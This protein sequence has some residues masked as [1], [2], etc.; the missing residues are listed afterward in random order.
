MSRKRPHPS[1]SAA[2]EGPIFITAPLDDRSS[3]FTGAFSPTLSAAALQAHEPFRRA[4]HRIAAWQ[5]AS[6]RTT[7][8]S[9]SQPRLDAGHDDDGERGGGRVVQRV[10][11]D[12]GVCGA[13]V[14]ARWFGSIMLGPVRF[15]HMEDRARAALELWRQSVDAAPTA[16]DGS[17]DEPAK[18]RRVEPPPDKEHIARTLRERDHSIAVLRDLL[19]EKTA[20]RQPGSSPA[21][22]GQTP[23]KPPDY[24]KMAIAALKAMEKARDAT[25]AFLLK[26]ID[27]VE[28]ETHDDDMAAAELLADANDIDDK[29]EHVERNSGTQ[30]KDDVCPPGPATS[31]MVPDGSQT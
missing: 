9:G 30:D 19:A 16:A 29:E 3:T 17:A 22:R 2:A 26:E 12:A 18:K 14:V 11:E 24:D 21:S 10:L 31:A 20:Q 15:R 7:L 6:R 4:T 27:R 8:T 23:K 13:L 5:T 28:S 25:I 1:S